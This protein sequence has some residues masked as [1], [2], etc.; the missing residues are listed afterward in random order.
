MYIIRLTYSEA[1]AWTPCSPALL[2]LGVLLGPLLRRLFEVRFSVL[3]FVRDRTLNGIVSMRIS[4]AV[5]TSQ[6]PPP[7]KSNLT[8]S[9]PAKDL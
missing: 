2:L 9:V 8:G 7:A 5:S 4:N 3:E 1:P 6:S